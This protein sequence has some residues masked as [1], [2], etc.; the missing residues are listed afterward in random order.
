MLGGETLFDHYRNF[1]AFKNNSSFE[2]KP[3]RTFPRRPVLLKNDIL[4]FKAVIGAEN[5][6]RN[7]SESKRQP[8]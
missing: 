5:H 6:K 7:S 2:M 3:V 8:P 4:C 1:S